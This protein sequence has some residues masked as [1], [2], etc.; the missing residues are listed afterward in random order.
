LGIMYELADSVSL[1]A[2]KI[3]EANQTIN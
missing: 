1:E 2:W 3:S